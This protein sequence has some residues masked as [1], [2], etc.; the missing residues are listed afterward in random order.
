MKRSHARPAKEC[1]DREQGEPEKAEDRG[2]QT[3]KRREARVLH[4]VAPPALRAKYGVSVDAAY[5]QVLPLLA[6]RRRAT[7]VAS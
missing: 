6:G 2:G 1:E 5:A 4:S 3:P 7:L